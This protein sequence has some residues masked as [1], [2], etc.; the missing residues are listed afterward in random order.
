MSEVLTAD[1]FSSHVDGRFQVGET[2]LF[3]TLVKVE[4]GQGAADQRV[5]FSLIFAGPKSPWAPENIWAMRAPDGVVYDIY[6]APIHT[7]NPDRQDYQA[8][9]N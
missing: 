4:V 3:L 5:P 8:V 2:E 1:L 9:F 7:P 6:I